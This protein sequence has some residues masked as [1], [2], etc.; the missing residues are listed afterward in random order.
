[1][2]RNND[3]FEAYQTN[4]RYQVFWNSVGIVLKSTTRSNEQENKC[5]RWDDYPEV[6]WFE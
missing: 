2:G 6:L 1:M 4:V 3:Y 5:T